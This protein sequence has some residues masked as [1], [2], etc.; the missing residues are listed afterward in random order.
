AARVSPAS[1]ISAYFFILI[2]FVVK[3]LF[4]CSLLW[5][6]YIAYLDAT[7]RT[8]SNTLTGNLAFAAY[9]APNLDRII[10]NV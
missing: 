10:K 3:L 8:I 2:L 4:M 1:A 6:F 5:L 7:Q 9:A